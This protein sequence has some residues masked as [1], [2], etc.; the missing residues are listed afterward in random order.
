ME[1]VLNR[2]CTFGLGICQ[3][4]YYIINYPLYKWRQRTQN[5]AATAFST[6]L[7]TQVHHR[8]GHFREGQESHSHPHPGTRRNQNPAKKQNKRHNRRIESNSVATYPETST[9]FLYCPTLRSHWNIGQYLHGDGVCSKWVVLRL[10]HGQPHVIFLSF[11]R[12]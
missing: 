5:S 8:Q 6:P 4:N 11:R 9:P 2:L 7:S 12:S 10:H 3:G 1:L